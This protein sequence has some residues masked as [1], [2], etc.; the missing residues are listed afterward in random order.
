MGETGSLHPNK[1]VHFSVEASAGSRGNF[2]ATLLGQLF[3]G[4]LYS[5][6]FFD[7]RIVGLIIGYILPVIWVIGSYRFLKFRA[8]N[9]ESLPFPGF[10]RKDPGNMLVI[11]VDILFL[12]VIWYIILSGLY[13]ATWLKF[14]FTIFFPLL[15]LSMMRSLVIIPQD[16]ENEKNE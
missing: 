3:I 7:F 12:S 10:I 15:T 13:D 6:G 14:V 4:L 11:I 2:R 1:I 5:F 16:K 9:T 8:M